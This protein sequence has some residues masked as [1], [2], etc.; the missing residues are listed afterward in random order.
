M[1]RSGFAYTA[2]LAALLAYS[3]N[4]AAQDVDAFLERLKAV[5]AEQGT[6]LSWDGIEQYDNDDGDPVIGLSNVTVEAGGEDTTIEL[7]ELIDV[8]EEDGGW[9]I[10]SIYVPEHSHQDG[11][12]SFYFSELSL[13]GLTIEAEGQENAY[14]GTAFYDGMSLGE[15][16][17]TVKG[18]DVFT[19]E[20]L[21]VEVEAAE[22]EEP[23][24]FSGGA[25]RFTA[26]P[27]AIEDPKSKAVYA[28]LGYN[29]VA[30]HMVVEGEWDPVSGR[31]SMSRYDIT[32]DELG[33]FGI[34]LEIGGYTPEFVKS[35][36]EMQAAMMANPDGDDSSRGLAMMGLMQQLTF[37]SARIHF[38]DDTL[39]NRVLELFAQQ[40]GTKARDVA[41]Q[42][43]AMVPFMMMQL[44]NQELTTQATTAASAFLD[45]PGTLA[46]TAQPASPVPFALIMA[47]A[48]SSPQSLPQTLGVT[49][50]ANE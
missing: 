40:Q 8:T 22:G 24:R 45:N 38:H 33:T 32:V 26:K 17:V 47:G 20:D 13:D 9:R 41:N 12:G 28:A 39:T 31:M 15:M 5:S 29:D 30:G 42:A 25:E 21:H 1:N 3:G 11:E 14:G 49:I 44:G 10:G 6:T 34:S 7:V 37:N 18:E 43:K 35:L 36:R 46:I 50:T 19:M 4:A 23:M 16:A 2:A 27:S 48:M